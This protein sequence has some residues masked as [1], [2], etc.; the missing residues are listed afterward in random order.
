[1]AKDFKFPDPADYPPKSPVVICPAERVLN[2]YNQ[3]HAGE[4][5]KRTS[6]VVRAWFSENAH[7]QGWDGVHFLPEVQT[8]HSAGAVLLSPH[9]QKQMMPIANAL[10]NQ[11]D[12]S[13][14]DEQGEE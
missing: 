4:E 9:G 6:K 13:P 8:N 1:M 10:L 12:V 5:A 14:E 7:Q 2:L 11:V 3:A